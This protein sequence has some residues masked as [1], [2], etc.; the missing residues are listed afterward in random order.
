MTSESVKIGYFKK[1]LG[2]FLIIISSHTAIGT[3]QDLHNLFHHYHD[4][5]ESI[6]KFKVFKQ[7]L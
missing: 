1:Q 3:G 6:K 7:N 5:H 2:Q 4:I